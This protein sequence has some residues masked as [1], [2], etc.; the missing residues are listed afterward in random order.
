MAVADTLAVSASE[1]F[2]VPLSVP[3]LTPS[4]ELVCVTDSQPFVDVPILASTLFYP[5]VHSCWLVLHS[6]T[7]FFASE[8]SYSCLCFEGSC[9]RAS[10]IRVG[11]AEV[12]IAQ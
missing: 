2:S 6:W 4:V 3:L 8:S 12:N 7:V 10:A 1:A 5:P 9:S 11:M